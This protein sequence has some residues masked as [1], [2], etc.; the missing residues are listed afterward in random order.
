M[1]DVANAVFDGVDAVMLS[2]ETANGIAPSNAVATMARIARCAEL[3][4]NHSQATDFIRDFTPKPVGTVE[5]FVSTAAKNVVDAKPGMVVVFSEG[6]K[7]ARLVAKYRPAVPVLLVTSGAV[8]ARSMAGTYGIYPM[9]LDAAPQSIDEIPGLVDKAMEYAVAKGLCMPGK[10]VLVLQSSANI[11]ED[12]RG[13]GVVGPEREMYFRVAPGEL[14]EDSLGMLAMGAE[15]ERITTKTLSMRST[16]I[17]L[18]NLVKD[19]TIARKT[20]I[21]CAIG[22]KC[23]SEEGIASL[24]DNGMDIARF[25]FQGISLE[26]NVLALETLR[27]VAEEKGR[28]VTVVMDVTG[29]K[30]MVTATRGGEAIALVNGQQV[31]LVASGDGA[32]ESFSDEGGATK[33]GVDYAGLAGACAV[34][35]RVKLDDGGVVLRVDK[36]EGSEVECTVV[37]GTKVKGGMMVWLAATMLPGLTLL[38][39]TDKSEILEFGIKQQVDMIAVSYV[40]SAEDVGELRK[41]LLINDA[42]D[43]KIIS[44]IETVQGL[45]AHEAIIEASDGII[46]AR[47][48]LGFALT[49][50]KVALAQK[51]LITKCNVANKFVMVA[52]Q[53]LESMI[54]NP[55]PTRAEMTDVANAVLDGADVVMLSGETAAGDFPG[56][57]VATMSAICRNAELATN[58]YSFFAFMR[59]MSHKPFG[60]TECAATSVC[61]S[62]IDTK[63]GLIVVMSDTG[64]FA[65]M[66]SKYRPPVPI[67]AMTTKKT[68][69]TALACQFGVVT[70]RVEAFPDNVVDAIRDS[71]AF[72]EERGLYVGGPIICV[73]GMNTATVLGNPVMRILDSLDDLH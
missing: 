29:P 31:F 30:V 71:V 7:T 25:S 68:T 15:D 44:K 26:D 20:K 10:E 23:W 12:K 11:A 65:R 22:P 4:V 39:P 36:V 73:H 59:D 48:D 5:A 66:C 17:S 61:K 35:Q 6:G 55:L 45:I 32:F 13:E 43:I 33:I 40:G 42:P 51:M 54:S 14:D 62:A 28:D 1:T 63:A 19:N 9:V 2:G 46:V 49:P 58:F 70:K 38:G 8:L 24:L 69:A 27:K 60:A 18:P 47:G 52:K 37:Q 53:M 64:K 3:G 56:K 72:A 57:C 34:G 67:V 21:A 41:F 16:K 50:E